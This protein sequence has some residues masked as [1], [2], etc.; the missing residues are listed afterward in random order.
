M[1]KVSS[2]NSIN[3]LK[4]DIFRTTNNIHMSEKRNI[5]RK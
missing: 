2:N 1:N 3:R 5:L 4:Y